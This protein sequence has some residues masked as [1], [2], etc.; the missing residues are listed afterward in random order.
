MI[1]ERTGDSPLIDPPTVERVIQAFLANDVDFCSNLLDETYPPGMSVRVFP[2][3]VLEEVARRTSDPVDHEHVSTYIYEVPGRFRL[4]SVESGYSPEAAALRL[5]LDTREDLEVIRT[6]YE[7]LY[8]SKPDFTLSDIIALFARR[9]ELALINK[10]VQQ[11]A[12]R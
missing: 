7:E 4:L 1:V 11:R 10:H 2:L 3:S 5:T 12:I 6:V 9:P 8:P